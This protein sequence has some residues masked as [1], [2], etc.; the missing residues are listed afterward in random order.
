MYDTARVPSA[1]AQGSVDMHGSKTRISLCKSQSIPASARRS[2][3]VS[4]VLVTS[5]KG[6]SVIG[7]IHNHFKDCPESCGAG[8]KVTPA[9]ANGY[10]PAMHT[11][12]TRRA[13]KPGALWASGP[14]DGVE[15][16]LL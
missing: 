10:H 12:S 13:K 2:G 4:R 3:F 15:L 8:T 1:V 5:M 6:Q 9:W 11:T 16:A 14:D 7:F